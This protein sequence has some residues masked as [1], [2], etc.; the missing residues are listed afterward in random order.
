MTTRA[1][2]GFHYR[3]SNAEIDLRRI[4]H[5]FRAFRSLYPVGTFICPM[6][7]ANAYGHGDVEV[8]R[9]LRAAG[10]NY[11]GVALVE[12]GESLR[13]GG[14]RGPIL[15]FGPA[16]TGSSESMM[17][18]NLTPVVSAWDQLD[19]LESAYAE[20]G[21]SRFGLHLEFNTGMNRLGFEPGE[22]SKLREWFEAHKEFRVEGV[23]THLF[24]GNDAGEMKGESHRQLERFSVIV[25]AFSDIRDLIVHALA[26][27]SS[28]NIWK[29]LQ[30]RK[31]V[32][33]S[34]MRPMGLRPGIGIY[35]VPPGNDEN[36]Q[37]SLKAVMSIKTHLISIHRIGKGERVSYGPT[38]TAERDSVIGTVP[39]GYADGYRRSLSNKASVLVRGQRA[40]QAGTICMDYFM[41]DLTDIEMTSGKPF[42]LGEEVVLLGDQG[43]QSISADELATLSGTIAYE[44]LTGISNRVTRTYL[45]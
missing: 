28:I 27:S 1:S 41:I 24:S 25:D 14:D 6:V 19:A 26:S 10:A 22:V 17:R 30:E 11:L 13:R 39:F 31:E 21:S 2:S 16:D 44:V 37:I 15:V 36:A 8:A 45:K 33:A 29:R 35:G 9:S 5:N 40:R 4:D 7:K 34:A 3:R 23:C 18:E 32:P 20:L 42:K 38:W 12:E 43:A